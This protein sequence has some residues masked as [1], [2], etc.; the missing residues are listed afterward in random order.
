MVR[1]FSPLGGVMNKPARPPLD[2]IPSWTHLVEAVIFNITPDRLSRRLQDAQDE[3]M[4]H[5]ED[6]FETATES[7]RQAM[8][9]TMNSLRELRRLVQTSESPLEGKIRN[10]SDA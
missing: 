9:N 5:I 7:E 3:I 6:S 4:D 2:S 1:N 8:I 10:F